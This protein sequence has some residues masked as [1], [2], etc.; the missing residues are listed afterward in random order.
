MGLDAELKHGVNAAA[1]NNTQT[2][3]IAFLNVKREK[4]N[5]R[6]RSF[7]KSKFSD[8]ATTFFR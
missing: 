3:S 6:L 4:S 8:S 7:F 2:M 5:Q 1:R